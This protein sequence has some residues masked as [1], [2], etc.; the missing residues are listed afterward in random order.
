MQCLWKFLKYNL[1]VVLFFPN[2][3]FYPNLGPFWLRGRER[4]YSWHK[5]SLFL[6]NFTMFVLPSRSIQMGHMSVKLYFRDLNL[7]SYSPPLL[8]PLH[9]NLYLWSKWPIPSRP[10][11]EQ[12]NFFRRGQAKYNKNKYIQRITH[13]HIHMEC[14]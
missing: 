8:L 3:I 11:V 12:E 13:T 2:I 14:L 4:E 1:L 7:S 10:V 6:V 5:I 9:K